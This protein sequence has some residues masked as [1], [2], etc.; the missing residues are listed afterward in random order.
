MN[1]LYVTSINICIVVIAISKEP[2]KPKAPMGC[3]RCRSQQ[4]WRKA[5]AGRPCLPSGFCN[6][7]RVMC[8][9][10]RFLRGHHLL[11]HL[12]RDQEQ[13]RSMGS[14]VRQILV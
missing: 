8:L 7:A 4:C 1:R 2:G 10:L 3:W 9:W 14:G 6:R 13:E 5:L 12:C 11:Q